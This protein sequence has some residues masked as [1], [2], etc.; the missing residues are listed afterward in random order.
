MG[1]QSPKK[2]KEDKEIALVAGWLS[3][4][5]AECCSSVRAIGRGFL[6]AGKLGGHTTNETSDE[7]MAFLS[8][9][10]V[11]LFFCFFCVTDFVSHWL[12]FCFIGRCLFC[13]LRFTCFFV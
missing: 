8:A 10:A 7:L 2:K 5:T 9:P 11:W 6:W 3:V 12:R 1:G 13:V 4:A